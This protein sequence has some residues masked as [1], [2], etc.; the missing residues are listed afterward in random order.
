MNKSTIV[1]LLSMGMLAITSSSF[2]G[3]GPAS[4]TNPPP[5]PAQGDNSAPP[6][7]GGPAGAADANSGD[8]QGNGANREE[9]RKWCR[10][11][12]EECK[13][14]H[15]QWCKD[16]PEKCK[17]KANKWCENH[18]EMCKEIKGAQ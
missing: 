9:R 5:P 10:E 17:E 11:H 7:P 4:G 16:H 3:A 8:M 18:P 14:K 12:P 15:E 13:A 1:F 2:A 6:P